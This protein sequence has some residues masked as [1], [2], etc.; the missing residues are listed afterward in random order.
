MQLEVAP[1]GG[2]LV[3]GR[4]GGDLTPVATGSDPWV[5]RYVDRSGERGCPRRLRVTVSLESPDTLRVD[6]RRFS[7]TLRRVG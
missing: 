3:A 4:C 2:T 7:G 1:S 5:F 6:A